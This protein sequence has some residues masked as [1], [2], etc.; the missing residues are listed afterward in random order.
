M[1]TVQDRQLLSVPYLR[2]FINGHNETVVCRRVS[3]VCAI[4][5]AVGTYRKLFMIA[6]DL[7]K[8]S[9]LS[10]SVSAMVGTLTWVD[11]L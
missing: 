5:Y 2:P 4:H 11:V 7:T 9:P 1:L 3:Q 10:D 6:L 8:F